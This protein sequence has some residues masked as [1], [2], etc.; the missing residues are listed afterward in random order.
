[1]SN[2]DISNEGNISWIVQ[3]QRI[4]KDLNSMILAITNEHPMVPLIDSN[5][6]NASELSSFVSPTSNGLI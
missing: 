4:V 3:S 6:F 5:S 1:M 2:V